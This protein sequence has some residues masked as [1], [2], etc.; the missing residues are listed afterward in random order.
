MK[1]T[2]VV[3]TPISMK[4]KEPRWWGTMASPSIGCIIVEVKTDEGIIGLGEAG[5]SSMYWPSVGPII[6]QTLKPLV[7]GEDPLLIEHLFT[8]MHRTTHGWG[9]RGFQTYAV[10]GIEIALWD[11]LGKVSGLPVWRLL[12]GFQQSIPA[13]WAPCLKPAKVI[14]KEAEG[15]VKAGFQAIK[16]RVGLGL[17][18]DLKIVKSVRRAVGEKVA[19]MVDAN[20]AYDYRTAVAMA[21]Q[22]LELG[23]RWL[24]EP[25]AT[26]SLTQYIEEH[27]RLN[28]ATDMPLAGGESLFTRWEFVEV[29]HQRAFDVVQPDAVSVGGIGETKK[30]AAMASSYNI[31][32]V[33]HIACSSVAGIGFAANLHIIGSLDNALYVEYDAYESPIREE[34]FQE[35]IKA[36]KGIVRMPE[37]PGLG[38]ELN[39]KALPKYAMKR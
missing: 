2:D 21:E 4:L 30:I 5:F 14:A 22:F 34:L 17:E 29:L 18:E 36:E 32:C 3:A 8:K 37:K 39:R 31:P 28:E 20:M 38:L 27:A 6:A 15:A 10:S 9:R 13:Y 35:P 25:I 16:L 1:I 33:P 7:L 12:G 19:L 11:I 24:E 23:V 26:H